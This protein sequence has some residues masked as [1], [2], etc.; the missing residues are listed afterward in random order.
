MPQNTIASPLRALGLAARA[1]AR[2]LAARRGNDGPSEKTLRGWATHR[3]S[4]TGMWSEAPGEGLGAAKPKEP[5]SELWVAATLLAAKPG[6]PERKERFIAAFRA[7]R[8]AEADAQALADGNREKRKSQGGQAARWRFPRH[9]AMK[10]AGRAF[11]AASDPDWIAELV[12]LGDRAALREAV[13]ALAG[14]S[15]SSGGEP[16]ER[17]RDELD[18]LLWPTPAKQKKLE[19][20][21]LAAR[22]NGGIDLGGASCRTEREAPEVWQAWIE[23]LRAL[24]DETPEAAPVS[25]DGPWIRRGRWHE[26]RLTEASFW[27]EKLFGEALASALGRLAEKRTPE[28]ALTAVRDA[29]LTA[30]LAEP[31]G[32]GAISLL[33]DTADLEDFERDWLLAEIEKRG[34]QKLWR[35]PRMAM[36]ERGGPLFLA[37]YRGEKATLEKLLQWCDPWLADERRGATGRKTLPIEEAL[38]EK[39]DSGSSPNEEDCALL[40]LAAMEREPRPLG[41]EHWASMLRN[42][43]RKGYPQIA[44]ALLARPELSVEAIAK[45]AESEPRPSEPGAHDPWTERSP[46]WSGFGSW[47]MNPPSVEILRRVLVPRDWESMSGKGHD[48]VAMAA[49]SGHGS[50]ER[51]RLLEERGADFGKADAQGRSAMLR[52]I[53]FARGAMARS[54]TPEA[55]RFLSSR[56]DV[57]RPDAKGRTALEESLASPLAEGKGSIMF[58][59]SQQGGLGLIDIAEAIA[60]SAAAKP[61]GPERLGDLFVRHAKK[62][63]AIGCAALAPWAPNPLPKGI[64]AKV[65]RIAGQDP[66]GEDEAQALAALAAWSEREALSVAAGLNNAAANGQKRGGRD[67]REEPEGQEEPKRSAPRRL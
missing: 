65:A 18:E 42:A 60:R 28:P 32:E 14:L 20:E 39:Y 38:E 57:E 50:V 54:L 64:G 26:E 9:E 23:A 44:E 27:R 58:K 4:P 67:R 61:G 45:A 29:L 52:T 1:V 47:S 30:M 63:S 25:W 7:Q 21:H 41:F 36:S 5:F 10:A 11:A 34:R 56:C 24:P 46:A 8:Q 33:A 40:L 62:G 12:A 37:A 3:L 49:A 43:L 35:H 13:E 48:L 22:P 19:A 31:A 16:W 59:A 2:A 66:S 17:P 51:L 15:F 55:A 6:S 53:D